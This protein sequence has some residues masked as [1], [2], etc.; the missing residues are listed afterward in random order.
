MHT[1]IIVAAQFLEE[2]F[3]GEGAPVYVVTW[4]EHVHHPQ[5]NGDATY[6]PC[7]SVQAAL[8]TWPEADVDHDSIDLLGPLARDRWLAMR[9]ERENSRENPVR[10]PQGSILIGKTPHPRDG[11]PGQV[12][13]FTATGIECL[14]VAGVVRSLPHDWRKTPGA[15]EF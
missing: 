8:T 14:L 13:R 12:I 11:E 2:R 10:L 4:P 9:S 1:P 5:Y 15:V 6:H 3:T 7:E